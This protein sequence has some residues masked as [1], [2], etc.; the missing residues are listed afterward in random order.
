MIY[1]FNKPSTI[2]AEL[3]PHA[4]LL[5]EKAA[6]TFDY[7]YYVPLEKGHEIQAM[8]VCSGDIIFSLKQIICGN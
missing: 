6:L 1:F 7:S 4:L 2:A 8:W 3:D 5:Y